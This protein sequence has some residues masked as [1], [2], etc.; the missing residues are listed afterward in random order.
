MGMLELLIGGR[1]D[2]RISRNFPDC[3]LSYKDNSLFTQHTEVGWEW[4]SLWFYQ[5]WFGYSS[6][7][8]FLL[9]VLACTRWIGRPENQLV[10]N[11]IVSAKMKDFS[12]WRWITIKMAIIKNSIDIFVEYSFFRIENNNSCEWGTRS[13]KSWVDWNFLFA[14]IFITKCLL[15]ATTHIFQSWT[16]AYIHAKIQPPSIAHLKA[17]ITCS[18]HDSTYTHTFMNLMVLHQMYQPCPQQLANTYSRTLQCSQVG[19][20]CTLGVCRLFLF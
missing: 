4:Q 17:C 12:T 19:C 15:N 18:P 10:M 11:Y 3:S 14:R 6:E 8:L 7:R 16:H 1:F 20:L 2:S 9:A 5:C 13:S